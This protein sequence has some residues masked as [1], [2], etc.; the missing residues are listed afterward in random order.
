[1][2]LVLKRFGVGQA[3]EPVDRRVE[4]GVADP[5]ALPPLRRAPE[6]AVATV[7]LP[8]ATVG[9]LP[10]LLHVHVDHVPGIAGGDRPWSAQVLTVGSDVADAVQAEPVQ[11][12]GHGPHAAADV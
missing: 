11:P 12:A 5:P 10:G 6:V 8:A 9:D 7:G 2:C 4:V 3:G 1:C